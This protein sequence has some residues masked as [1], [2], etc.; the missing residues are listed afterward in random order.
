MIKF[1]K[2]FIVAELGF[3]FC[4]NINLAKKMILEAKKSGVD[5]VKIQDFVA[6]EIANIKYSSQYKIFK[7]N[8]IS[9]KN[10]KI[11]NDFCK[12]N[13]II[14]F[15]F[16]FG[17]T[18]ISNA[19]KLNFP[20]IKIASG[21]I[22]NLF[23]LNEICKLKKIIVLSTGMAK[24]NE[25]KNAIKILKKSKLKF[26]LCHCTSIYPAELKNLNLNTINYFKKKFKCS[27]FL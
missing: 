12:R 11:L 13:K 24:I 21:D 2:T 5:A 25:I 22:T 26:I 9:L 14:F 1:K 6:S 3:N 17:T 4:K 16:L 23:L 10:L 8:Q 15:T 20:I 7:N 19:K 18:S 27:R